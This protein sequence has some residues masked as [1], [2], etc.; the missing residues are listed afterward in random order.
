MYGDMNLKEN[1]KRF[2]MNAIQTTIKSAKSNV[3]YMLS[4][5][6][7]LEKDKV[8]AFDLNKGIIEFQVC[9]W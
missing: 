5:Y 1:M 6:L 8:I 9:I 3:A 7:H 4:Q 2:A